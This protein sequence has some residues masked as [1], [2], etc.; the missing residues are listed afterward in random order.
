MVHNTCSGFQYICSHT[1]FEVI[2]RNS[3]VFGCYGGDI[4]V[5]NSRFFA[6]IFHF[7][8]HINISILLYAPFI[9]KFYVVC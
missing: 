7:D 8:F 1:V 2:G 5:N 9:T 6:D 3:C 4:D